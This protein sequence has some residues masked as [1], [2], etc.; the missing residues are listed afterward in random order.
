MHSAA[1][2]AHT[3][4]SR[5]LE[6]VQVVTVNSADKRAAAYGDKP[7]KPAAVQGGC[8][9]AG[10]SAAL[11]QQSFPFSRGD[12]NCVGRALARME[13]TLIVA[14]L[15]SAYDVQ[16]A[17]AAISPE[18]VR[19]AAAYKCTWCPKSLPMRLVPW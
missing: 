15:L 13:M 1:L 12:R 2:S 18:H 4:S 8:P 19:E 10:D 3:H 16:L 11:P 17:D 9:F 6:R 5:R 14:K 7:G